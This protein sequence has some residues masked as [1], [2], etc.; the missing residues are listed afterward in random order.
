MTQLQSAS[1]QKKPESS[2]DEAQDEPSY[3][4]LPHN[5][6]SEQVILGA[7]LTDNKEL[8]KIA[9]FLQDKHFYEPVHQRIYEAIMNF[10]ERGL[11]ATPV[12][13][14]NLF[15]GDEALKAAGGSSYLAR[16]AGLSGS[17]INIKDHALVV[18]NLALSR[19]LIDIGNEMVNSAYHDSGHYE[20]SRL[21]E[22]SE[23]QLFTLAS[24][25]GTQANFNTLGTAV[26]DAI[27][28]ANRAHKMQGGVSG[29]PTKFIDLD[30]LMGGLHNSDLLI[31]AARPSMGK[32]AF[33]L[34]VA[35]NAAEAFKQQRDALSPD[36]K[37]ATPVKSVGVVS[38]EMSSEQ[39]A[40][41]LLSLKTG[42]NASHIRRG[43]LEKSPHNDEFAKL[44]QASQDLHELNIFLD[45][46]PALSIA[47]V[48]TRA[49]R[50]KRKH[51]LSLLVVD[52]LQL[53]RGT[54]NAAKNNRVLEISEI[55]MGLK[56]I[57][58]E[59]KIPVIALSQLSRAVESR[60]DKRPQLSDLRES[61]SI[62]Q[63]ADIVMFLYREAYYIER[64]KPQEGTEAFIEWQHEM[65][66]VNNL[67]EVM[68]SK[69]RNG[70]IDNVTLFFDKNT[71]RFTD[72]DRQDGY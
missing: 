27:E 56:A 34:N 28:T 66:R 35:L 19:G 41:R 16:I 32:T 15:D 13:L 40:A 52:Y 49:R 38:L 47:A 22:E 65:E 45:D 25:G 11:I 46:T 69:N 44:V 50:L 10:S 63:D 62:E 31:L 48:R 70:P 54:S 14:K 9:D 36:E 7:L 67:C 20:S 18:Y 21:I 72:F 8:D 24:E 17:V 26:T 2:K 57:A 5:T 6:E 64:K 58:K 68:I 43:Q 29:T 3:R 33:A 37:Q 53:L 59:L 60:D 4:V 61:G 71:T 1:A 23:Q 51:N 55:T 30:R 39:L 42:I 12:T